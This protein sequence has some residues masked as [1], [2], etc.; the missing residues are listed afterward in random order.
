MLVLGGKS[1]NKSFFSMPPSM[2][3]WSPS[4]CYPADPTSG[5]VYPFR[6]HFI[7]GNISVCHGCKG[8]YQNLEP[9]YDICLHHE[10]W[11]TF[12]SPGSYTPQSRFGNVYYHCNIHCVKVVWPHFL[13]SCVVTPSSV[14]IRLLPEHHHFLYVNFGI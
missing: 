11:R 7:S 6:V 14:S 12:I 5:D 2:A 3:T 4:S 8:R 10:E 9:P 1:S 13:P